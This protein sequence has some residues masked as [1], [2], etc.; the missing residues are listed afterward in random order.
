M[1]GFYFEIQLN[2]L[3]IALQGIL[4]SFVFRNRVG[5]RFV[6]TKLGN[7]PHQHMRLTPPLYSVF[8]AGVGVN[9]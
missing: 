9:L 1:M 5:L 2:P 7:L 4:N 6:R 3:K 8:N